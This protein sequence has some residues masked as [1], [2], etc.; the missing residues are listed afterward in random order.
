MNT[1]RIDPPPVYVAWVL[2]HSF[3]LFGEEEV[4]LP[5]RALRGVVPEHCLVQ[6]VAERAG[7]GEE[8]HAR[9]V[10]RAVALTL[11]ARLAGRAEVLRLR[12]PAARTRHDVVERQ[13]EDRPLRAAVLAAHLVARQ[14]AH[15]LLARLCAP[16]AHVD[17]CD[18][19]DHARYDED[20]MLRAQH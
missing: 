7:A 17:V 14:N 18:Q 5:L 2:G 3:I 13:L 19:T 20:E 10:G 8:R 6:P 9:L 15:A 11:V 4:G 16:P 12:A 1:L